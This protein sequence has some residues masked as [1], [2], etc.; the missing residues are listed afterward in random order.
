MALFS[1]LSKYSDVGLLILRVGVGVMMMTHGIPKL[2]GGPEMWKGVGE[3][4]SNFGITFMP[5]AWGFAAAFAEGI[6]G[7]LLAIG[8]ASRIAAFLLLCTM[9]VA[10]TMH[11]SNGDGLSGASHAMELA[12]VFFGL[13]FIGPGK[14]SV[15][16]G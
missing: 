3:S 12:F 10:A 4:M 11:L 15:D 8:L 5:V 16:K 7:L 1:G 2:A 14:Y 9:I 6:G 13:I